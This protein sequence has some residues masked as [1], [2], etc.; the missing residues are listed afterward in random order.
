MAKFKARAR[1]LDMLGRQQIAG[2]PTAVSELFKNAYDAYAA[3]VEADFFRQQNLFVLR[4][5][6]IGMTEED[7]RSRWLSVGTE[8]KLGSA[9]GVP[10]PPTPPGKKTRPVMGEKGIGRLAIAVLGPQVLVLTR[11]ERD[12]KL[13]DLVAAFINWRLF[14]LPGIDLDQIEVPLRTFPGGQ[15]PTKA[16]VAAMVQEARANLRSLLEH[17]EPEALARIFQ[18]FDAFEVDPVALAKYLGKPQL[19]KKDTGTHFIVRP[20]SDMLAASIDAEGYDKAASPLARTLVGFTNV[21]ETGNEGLQ[22]EVAFR[23]R[24]NNEQET[25]LISQ[26]G[27]FAPEDFER[28][29]HLIEGQFDE[30]GKFTGTVRVYQGE[31]NP[32]EHRPK[33]STKKTECGPFSI[34]FAYVLGSPRESRLGPLEHAEVNRR[35]ERFGGIYI[36]RDG[37]RVQP[38][39]DPEV[40]F[41]GIEKRRSKSASYYFFSYRRMFGYIDLTRKHNARLQEKAGREG[42]QESTAYKQFR[43]LL[44]N[45]LVQLAA[46]FFREGGERSDEFTA[47]KAELARN[48][49]LRRRREE[50]S[51]SLRAKLNAEAEAMLTRL[52]SGEPQRQAEELARTVERDLNEAVAIRPVERAVEAVLHVEAEARRRLKELKHEYQVTKPAGMALDIH[53]RRTWNAYTAQSKNLDKQ[54][55]APARKRVETLVATAVREANLAVDR[56]KRAEHALADS[57]KTARSLVRDEAEAINAEVRRLQ[58]QATENTRTSLAELER[59]VGST[60]EEF[61][62]FDALQLDDESFVEKRM[63]LEQNIARTADEQSEQLHRLKERLARLS[64]SPGATSPEEIT[65]ALEEELLALR[66]RADADLELTQLGMAIEVINHEFG[67]SIRAVRS[68]LQ[69]LKAWSDVNPKLGLVY[70][71]LRTSFEHLDGYLTLFTPLHRRLYRSPVEFTG[72]DIALFLGDLFRERLGRHST[73]L[74]ATEAFRAFRIIGYQSTFYPVF[75]NLVDNALFWMA[76]RPEPRVVTLD[77]K[78]EALLVSDTGPGI[79]ARDCEAIFEQGFSRKPGGRGLGLYIS[80]SVLAKAGWNLSLEEPTAKSGAVFRM[81]PKT[82]PKGA[83]NHK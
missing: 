16:D 21:M 56:I 51:R 59:A 3:R 26:S 72:A 60:M 34:R 10:P 83:G 36:Y 64:F 71:E 80:R 58:S 4:D 75:V 70:R 38:Y 79:A 1:A 81:E 74:V 68:N 11:A 55:L 7:F 31:P 17:I 50:E 52:Q 49:Q 14:S 63:R 46:D 5:D 41:L 77:A 44:G 45:F 66:E 43:D 37:I 48:A 33:F 76:D 9:K 20:V 78:R 22:F 82:T 12:G 67:A 27:F 47:G 25:E 69:R 73:R 15:L 6:G 62:R 18:E 24:P 53:L 42:F 30:F 35:L 8:S 65:E 28:T 61:A 13:Q 32:Y 29:D 19:T 40:D 2:V 57:V 23:D 39:G 54:V